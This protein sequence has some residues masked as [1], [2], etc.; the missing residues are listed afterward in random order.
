MM[1]RWLRFAAVRKRLK[2]KFCNSVASEAISGQN[3]YRIWW[4]FSGQ[5][6][7]PAETGFTAQGCRRFELLRV[8]AK[9]A[10]RNLSNHSAKNSIANIR[11]FGRH[12]ADPVPCRLKSVDW[13][14]TTD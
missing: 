12:S 5:Q 3:V 4:L 7:P 2:A 14:D 11:R 8:S 1:Y 6:V 13:R 9:R 10:F